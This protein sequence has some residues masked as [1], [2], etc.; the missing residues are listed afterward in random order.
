[1]LRAWVFCMICMQCSVYSAEIIKNNNL[2]G[3]DKADWVWVDEER[4]LQPT[5]KPTI[6]PTV[7]CSSTTDE[8]TITPTFAPTIDCQFD[9]YTPTEIPTNSPTTKTPTRNPTKK[10]CDTNQPTILP[11]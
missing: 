7:D 2:R 3:S 5:E 1:M 4:T 6:T 10:K 8:P 11:R 9:T